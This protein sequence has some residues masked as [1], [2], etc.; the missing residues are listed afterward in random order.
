MTL[1]SFIRKNRFI[2]IAPEHC[3]DVTF[4]DFEQIINNDVIQLEAEWLN[5]SNYFFQGVKQIWNNFC[6][7]SLKTYTKKTY[8]KKTKTS[9]LTIKSLLLAFI[10]FWP[11]R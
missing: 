9:D 8:T 7:I 11:E 10:F 2:N 4:A 1:K 5:D 3:F 6:V